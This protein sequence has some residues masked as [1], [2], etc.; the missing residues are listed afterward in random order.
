[1]HYRKLRDKC[2]GSVEST[3]PK[4]LLRHFVDQDSASIADDVDGVRL[5][6]DE[7]G[8]DTFLVRVDRPGRE[9]PEVQECPA[10]QRLAGEA[11]MAADSPAIR[12][13]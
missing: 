3:V 4:D 8:T 6:W 1:M 11:L 10:V 13:D 9:L 5:R 12:S 7:L 2:D